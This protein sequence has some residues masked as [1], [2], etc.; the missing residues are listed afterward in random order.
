MN[1]R[2][3]MLVFFLVA[4]LLSG[5]MALS[6]S[7]QESSEDLVEG[8]VTPAARQA[9]RSGLEYL[10]GQQNENGS[11]GADRLL[12][13]NT[14]VCGLA[15]LAFLSEG[16]T[17]D[18]GTYSSNIRLCMSFL[19]SHCDGEGLIDNPD[20]QSS[21]PMYGHGFATLFLAEI[22]GMPGTQTLKPKIEKAVGLIVRT[23]GDS[24]GWRYQPNREDADL[25][26]TVCQL[27]A[28]RA[29]R[30]AGFFVPTET[31]RQG[32]EYI[33]QSRNPDGGFCY[34][35]TGPRDSGFARSAAA[36]VGLQSAG[37]YSGEEI[38][39]GIEYLFDSRPG[40]DAIEGSYYYYG[41][42]YAV[43]AVWQRGGTSWKRWF[44]AIRDELIS[45]QQ[46]SSG[47]WT[48]RYSP[49]YSTAMALIVLQIPN[50]I[51]PIFQR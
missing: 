17:T 27:M 38:T 31:I 1:W 43:Q 30:N 34:Q 4:G 19:E 47:S 7:T 49:E 35:L 41:H 46:S 5:G 48:S 28:L 10:A 45:R 51:L 42:Y 20:Y 37:I 3:F 24:G 32:I 40:G 50:N 21:G 18:S 9:I 26:V 13:G 22:Y 14:G 8:M 23:Q 2:V 36:L 6:R 29:A 25:S 16:S 33:R 44:P 39:R 15:G 12:A 11:F